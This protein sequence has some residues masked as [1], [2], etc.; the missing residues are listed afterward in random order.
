MSKSTKILFAANAICLALFLALAFLLPLHGQSQAEQ[1]FTQLDKAGAINHNQVAR[2]RITN[3][4]ADASPKSAGPWIA[5][6]AITAS[7]SA[8]NLGIGLTLLN[9]SLFTASTWK[10]K[11]KR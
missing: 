4:R 5:A 9:V 11:K 8:A 3:D 10:S 6:P 2:M 1:R 7:R